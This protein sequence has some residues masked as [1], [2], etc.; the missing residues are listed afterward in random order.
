MAL[1]SHDQPRAD[2]CDGRQSCL[3]EELLL[4]F[5]SETNVA[6]HRRFLLLLLLRVSPGRLHVNVLIREKNVRQQHERRAPPFIEGGW[7]LP[8]GGYHWM[9]GHLRDAEGHAVFRGRYLVPVPGPERRITAPR[10]E[11]NGLFRRFCDLRTTEQELQRF[12]SEYGSLAD[13]GT[14]LVVT[15]RRPGLDELGV[16][17]VTKAR[18]EH[19]IAAMR[20]AVALWDAIEVGDDRFIRERVERRRIH[21]GKIDHAFYRSPRDLVKRGY[22]PEV[23]IWD[24]SDLSPV[25]PQFARLIPFDNL[26]AVALLWLRGEINRKLAGHVKPQLEYARRGSRAGELQLRLAPMDVLGALWLDFAHTIENSLARRLV[27]RVCPACGRPFDVARDLK[28]AHAKFCGEACRQ[29][30]RY[31]KIKRARALAANGQPVAAIVRE[32]DSSPDTVRRWLRKK[33]RRRLL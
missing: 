9:V 15:Q 31:A 27:R 3:R 18:W 32:L 30:N 13:A 33:P 5:S 21:E 10:Q 23:P 16:P 6:P 14:E 29:A 20:H 22:R 28:R 26:H 11:L 8:E 7:N 19:E 12:A 17:G 25:E 24:T 4:P 1:D 2:P